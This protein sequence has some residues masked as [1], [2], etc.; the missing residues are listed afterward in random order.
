MSEKEEYCMRFR[1][2]LGDPGA[3]SGGEGKSKR[4]KKIVWRKVKNGEKSSFPFFCLWVSEDDFDMDF[5]KSYLL[6]FLSK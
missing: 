5:K 3:D 4:A 6:L 1:H 2:I